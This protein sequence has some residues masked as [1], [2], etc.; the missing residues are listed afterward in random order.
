MRNSVHSTVP[1]TGNLAIFAG[2]VSNGI[3]PVFMKEYTRWM[4]VN[5]DERRVLTELHDLE[6]MDNNQNSMTNS[7]PNPQLG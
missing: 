7:P 4:I 3:E 6:I 5:E 2:Q 1:P